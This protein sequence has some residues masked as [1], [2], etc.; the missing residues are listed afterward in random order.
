M[1]PYLYFQSPYGFDISFTA[2]IGLVRDL[3]WVTCLLTLGNLAELACRGW[4]N[5]GVASCLDRRWCRE[6][7]GKLEPGH[8]STKGGRASGAYYYAACREVVDSWQ[9]NC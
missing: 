2:P 3:A 6:G 9:P 7:L 8:D 5:L 1:L 4:L